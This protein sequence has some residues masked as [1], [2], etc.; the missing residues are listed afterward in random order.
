MHV[1]QTVVL[2]TFLRTG[3][4]SAHSPHLLLRFTG[5]F[6]LDDSLHFNTPIDYAYIHLPFQFYLHK[7]GD[8]DTLVCICTLINIGTFF[9]IYICIYIYS[10][11]ICSQKCVFT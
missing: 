9:N 6:I 5:A 1:S 8:M 11:E 2:Y 7:D 4:S 10:R 3:F